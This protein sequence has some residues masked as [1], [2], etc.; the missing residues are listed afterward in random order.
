MTLDS[1]RSITLKLAFV[2]VKHIF[3]YFYDKLCSLLFLCC[4]RQKSPFTQAVWLHILF[5]SLCE[6]LVSSG[7]TRSCSGCL[8]YLTASVFQF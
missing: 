7:G 2:K 8:C 1:K 4:P 5:L 3:E 6:V